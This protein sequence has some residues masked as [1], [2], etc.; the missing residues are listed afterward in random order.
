[1][2]IEADVDDVAA[3]A[4]GMSA[5]AAWMALT[6]RGRFRP[7]ER[8]LVLGAGGAV[9]Q[10]AVGAARALGAGRVVAVCRS[11]ESQERARRAGA[12]AVVP[13]D[14]DV[15]ALAAAFGEALGGGA[16]VVVDPVCGT[17][18]TAAARVLAPAAGW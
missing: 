5:V 10:V 18:A 16:D 12:D 15:D 17:A 3:A 13:L 2:P 14:G 1:M 4:L 11:A 7:G 9:G 6:E 8:V